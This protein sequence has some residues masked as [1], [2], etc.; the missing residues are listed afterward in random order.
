MKRK[1]HFFPE[2]DLEAWFF[3]LPMIALP[4]LLEVVRDLRWMTPGDSY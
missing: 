1:K 3:L 4:S 2:P